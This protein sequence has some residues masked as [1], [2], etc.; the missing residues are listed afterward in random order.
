MPMLD[1]EEDHPRPK[2]VPGKKP[3]RRQKG[4]PPSLFDSLVFPVLVIVIAVIGSIG[5]VWMYLNHWLGV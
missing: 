1:R 2:R 5:L 3:R 4:L